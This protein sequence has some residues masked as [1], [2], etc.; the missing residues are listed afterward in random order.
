MGR[1]YLNISPEG[2]ACEAQQGLLIE[3][4]PE[5]FLEP[6]FLRFSSVEYLSLVAAVTEIW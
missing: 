1:K 4:N 5:A 6:K 3:F 2:A